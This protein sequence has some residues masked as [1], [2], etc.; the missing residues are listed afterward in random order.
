MCNDFAIRVVAHQARLKIDAGK[1]RPLNREVCDF[2]F[3]QPELERDGLEARAA[4]AEFL[5]ARDVLDLDQVDRRKAI[6]R[7]VNVFDLLRNQFELVGRQVLRNDAALAIEDRPR[8]GGTGSIRTRL[9][10]DFS[11]NS[12]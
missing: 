1:S 5:E 2:L 12:S 10:C 6:Q 3:R 7:V 11:A 8:I 9:P 4:A